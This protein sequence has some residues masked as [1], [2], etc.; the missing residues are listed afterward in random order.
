M[1]VPHR[2]A[3]L[4]SCLC[5][6]AQLESEVFQRWALRLGEGGWLHRKIWEWCYIAEALN[7]RG[8][9]Q[10]ERR[11]LGFAVGQEP[12]PSL[13]AS[14]GCDIVATDLDSRRAAAAGWVKTN[15]HAGGLEVLNARGLCPPDTFR[16]RVSFE[17]VDMNRIPEHLRHF[18]FVWSSCSLEHLG[19]LALG[20]QFIYNSLACLRPGGVAIHTTEYN[21]TSNTHTPDYRS[22]VLFR[23][24]DLERIAARATEC[25]HRVAPLDLRAGEMPMDHFVDVPPYRHDP[26]LKVQLREHVCTSVGLIIEKRTDRVPQAPRYVTPRTMRAVLRPW[27]QWLKQQIPRWPSRRTA[28]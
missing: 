24:C 23:R 6:Q 4:Q 18:D 1:I 21:V 25:G 8:M 5:T 14:V 16:Q 12:L 11:G 26:H 10:P 13:L 22:T 7:E 28:A 27:G 17:H 15:Q 20:E 2:T 19:S 3:R 9:L